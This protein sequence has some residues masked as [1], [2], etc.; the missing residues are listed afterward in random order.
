MKFGVP[1]PVTGS[2]PLVAFQCAHGMKPACPK[3]SLAMKTFGIKMYTYSRRRGSRLSGI[4]ATAERLAGRDIG[5]AALIGILIN[6]G[7][8]KPERRFA[9]AKACI[10]QECN[11][12]SHN[13]C[14]RRSTSIRT[15]LSA[16]NHCITTSQL[17]SM[18]AL[19]MAKLTRG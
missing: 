16:D 5:E 11:N 2:H 18:E 8:Q 12:A 10:V 13:G 17:A 7:I 1:N 14:G 6:Q 19:N 9:C 4:S 15:K 3:V